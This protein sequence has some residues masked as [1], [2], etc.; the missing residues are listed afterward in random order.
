M[1]R[2]KYARI[3]VD[4]PATLSFYQ[5]EGYHSGIVADISEGGCLFPF[6]DDAQPGIPCQVT[7]TV[8]AGLEAE[9]LTIAGEVVRCAPEGIGIRFLENP[10]AQNN[11]FADL[12]NAYRLKNEVFNR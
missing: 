8:G 5:V 11:R 4:I 9:T 7:I 2:R 12:L 1:E 10:L 6:D 3:T